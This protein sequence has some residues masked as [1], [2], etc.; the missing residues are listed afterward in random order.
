M[1]IVIDEGEIAVR[2]VM[3]AE[4]NDVLQMFSHKYSVIVLLC[5]VI[6]SPVSYLIIDRY[7]STFAYRTAISLWVFSLALVIVLIVTLT[8]VV[9]RSFSAATR[10][11]VESIK[12][13]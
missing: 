3:G 6:A 5:F 9:V 8:I 11:P 13:E 1:P 7:F 2:R 12:A 10:N 4:V